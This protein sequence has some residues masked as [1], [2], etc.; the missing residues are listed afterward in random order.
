[1]MV[2]KDGK[3]V[4]HDCSDDLT[5]HSTELMVGFMIQGMDLGLEFTDFALQNLSLFGYG[6]FFD[7]G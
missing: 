1:M 7:R 3:A 5:I 4:V 2:S 6:I